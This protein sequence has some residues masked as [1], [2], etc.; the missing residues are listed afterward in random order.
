MKAAA[1]VLFLP[2]VLAGCVGGVAGPGG[3][4]SG[5]A[6]GFEPCVHPWPCADGSEWPVGLAGPFEL[7]RVERVKLPGH[8]GVL[9]DG[10]IW[11]PSVPAG[12][13]LPV[14]LWSSPYWGTSSPYPDSPDVLGSDH[15]PVGFLVEQG[16][17]VALVSVRGT[18][19]SEGCYESFGRNEQLDHVELVGWLAGQ[20]WSN[21]RAGMMGLSYHGTTPWEAAIHAPPALKTIVVAGMISD[22]YTF[23]HTPQGAPFTLGGSFEARFTAT[24]TAPAGGPVLFDGA[25]PERFLAEWPGTLA[26]RACPSV[27]EVA[28]RPQAAYLEE[29][30]Q[31]PFWIERRL[32]DGFANVTAA[33]LLTHG[34]EDRWDS[35]HAQQELA[36]W[37]ALPATTPRHLLEGQW[38][39]EFPNTN[40]FD[41][42]WALADWHDRMVAWFDFWLK[43]LGGPPAS[44]GTAAYQD[45]TLQWHTSTA[46]P[47]AEARDEVL[48][49][50]DGTLTPEAPA[51]DAPSAMFRAAPD[52]TVD[53]GDTQRAVI[54]PI[55]GPTGPDGT[56][57]HAALFA[58]EPLEAP[59]LIAGNPFAYLTL[60][61]DQPS[62][63]VAVALVDL[64][65]DFACDDL[66]PTGVRALTW[67]AADLR[68]HQGGYVAAPFPV[69]QDHGVRVDLTNLA[70]VVPEGH[71]LGVVL[72][73][74][75]PLA[76]SA[77]GH[78]PLITVQAASHV[79]IPVVEGSFGGDAPTLEYPPRPFVPV[80][81][82]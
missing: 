68:F 74:G 24:T 10:A 58:S 69:D 5:G 1:V 21:G 34:F 80:A 2:M 63:L 33:V 35:G 59:A 26:H 82:S 73:Y 16:Y 42:A 25:S 53:P 23:F 32:I 31:A 14:V 4:G 7:D 6:A 62:G 43:G 66:Q 17:A 36:A 29:D 65:P 52:P 56:L 57:P 45:D 75:E 39:H 8:E 77:A 30:R 71:R 46:W 19:F 61:S 22:H 38:G 11:F 47:P 41:P 67:G 15:V 70:M 40:A 3:S 79:V 20:P 76:R 37:G 60:Q 64:A 54:G 44:L 9:L 28:S 27:L 81:G 12:M 49:L 50:A 18:G 13:R 78:A 48:H 51:P 55:C 72:S